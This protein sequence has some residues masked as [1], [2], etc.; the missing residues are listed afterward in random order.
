[1]FRATRAHAMSA[2]TAA[3]SIRCLVS[4]TGLAHA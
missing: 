3:A 4:S 2:T 1:M